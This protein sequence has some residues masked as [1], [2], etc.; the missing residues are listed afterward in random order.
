MKKIL[1]T[2]ATGFVG[3]SLSTSL[4][5]AAFKNCSV[6]SSKEE[7]VNGDVLSLFNPYLSID[8]NFPL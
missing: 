5:R 1:I 8:V 4:N 2:G 3:N 6:V 7:R